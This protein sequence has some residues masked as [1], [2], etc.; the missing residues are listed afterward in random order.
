ME[1]NAR[2]TA[3]CAV[4]V[5]DPEVARIVDA[6][7]PVPVPRPVGLI[8][9]T[10]VFVEFQET[11]LVTFCVL[12]SLYVA[13]AVNCSVDPLRIDGVGGATEMDA[14]LGAKTANEVDPV[15][16]PS[17]AWTVEVPCVTPVANPAA[18]IVTLPLL[19]VQPTPLTALELPSP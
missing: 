13:I 8:D 3:A 9:T 17:F 16:D 19:E 6:P 18:L 15:I 1:T 2:V 14:R 10:A 5:I 12:P 11:V 7:T 4:P